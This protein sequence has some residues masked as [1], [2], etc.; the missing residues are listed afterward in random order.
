MLAGPEVH[1]VEHDSWVL[2]TDRLDTRILGCLLW[3]KFSVAAAANYHTHGLV[4]DF[5]TLPKPTDDDAGAFPDKTQ[6]I[7]VTSFGQARG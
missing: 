3:A 6:A 5:D 1:C 4:C 7:R 2:V